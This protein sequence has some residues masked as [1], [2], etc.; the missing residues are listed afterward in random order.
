MAPVKKDASTSKSQRQLPSRRA[1]RE[2]NGDQA[3]AAPEAQASQEIDM[4]QS[5]Q[6]IQDTVSQTIAKVIHRL[7]SPQ[8]LMRREGERRRIET[9]Y[10]NTMEKL[11]EEIGVSFA[12]R[13]TRMSVLSLPLQMQLG[14][15][16]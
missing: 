9:E 7:T 12:E 16:D 10:D 4:L 3:N 8:S 2:E 15:Y 14:N 5:A 6:N 1:L 13:S 11:T